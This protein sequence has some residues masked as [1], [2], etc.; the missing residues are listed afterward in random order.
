MRQIHTGARRWDWHD[1]RTAMRGGRY[2]SYVSL[3]MG[4]TYPR[5]LSLATAGRGSRDWTISSGFRGPWS[6]YNPAYRSPYA[7]TRSRP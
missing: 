3:L 6:Q 2:Y 1:S 7:A 4:A 5:M